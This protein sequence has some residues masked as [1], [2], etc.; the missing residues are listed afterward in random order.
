MSSEKQDL[1]VQK[2]HKVIR[3]A[4]MELLK[5]KPFENIAI[6]EIL[7]RALVNR[8]TFYKY[9][10]GKS[11]LAGVMINEFKA[12]YANL[13]DKRKQTLDLNKFIDD[14]LPQFYQKREV[15]L[16]LWKIKTK[17]HHLW[18]DMFLMI[19]NNYIATQQAKLPHHNLDYQG[20]LVATIILKTMQYYFERN[21]TIP[22]KQVWN[23]IEQ[24]LKAL[25]TV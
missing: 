15:I 19:K 3:T 10:S 9:Y 17:R 16:M 1:R 21:S 12:E 13:I 8:N 23:E 7:E 6:Q 4:F 18:D 22:V 14:I 2:T 20:E 25:Q 11:D 5:E 24:I